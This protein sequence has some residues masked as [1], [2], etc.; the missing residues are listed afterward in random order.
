MKTK[1]CSTQIKVYCKMQGK[2]NHWYQLHQ[3]SKPTYYYTWICDIQLIAY[4]SK[5]TKSVLQNGTLQQG[6]KHLTLNML[7]RKKRVGNHHFTSQF[8]LI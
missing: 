8:A 4:E 2:P 7:M 5:N 1:L 3:K 6:M